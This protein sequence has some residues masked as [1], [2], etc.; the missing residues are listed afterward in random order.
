[1]EP[2]R[3]IRQCL[4]SVCVKQFSYYYVKEIHWNIHQNILCCLRG[5]ILCFFKNSSVLYLHIRE[6]FTVWT[7]NL[8]VFLNACSGL[9]R[10]RRLRQPVLVWKKSPSR[11]VISRTIPCS[12]ICWELRG[13]AAA[14]AGCDIELETVQ[15][16]QQRV[17]TC[18][19][20]WFMRFEGHSS[21]GW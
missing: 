5:H 8:S 10:Q 6:F 17:K 4:V 3:Y 21:S 20:R 19:R 9:A 2:N 13:C 18:Q 15:H 16:K 14:L 1:M 11:P 7:L 12:Q